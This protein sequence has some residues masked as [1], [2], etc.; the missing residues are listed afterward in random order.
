MAQRDYYEVLGVDRGAS[1]DEI[2]SAYRKLAMKYHPDR[3]PDDKSSEDRFK[4]A[5]EAYEVLKDPQKR[6]TFD[7]FGHA[8]LG[9]GAGGFGF[10]GGFDLGDALR[11]FMRDFGGGG[12]IFDE[13][14]GMGGG[15]SRPTK[16]RRGSARKSQAYSRGDSDRG[17]EED[18]GQASDPLRHLRWLGPGRRG[19]APDLPSVW[20]RRA[21]AYDLANVFGDR[22][23]SDH[24]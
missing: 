23:T 3:N 4:E 8:G 12:S 15:R 21:G 13:M 5:T 18:P 24:L 11:A 17:R 10:S 14:F 16:S 19:L 22:T 9:Q 2:K 1:E 20:G 6:Q 7:R